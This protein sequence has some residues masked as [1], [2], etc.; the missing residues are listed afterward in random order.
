MTHSP[1]AVTNEDAHG[2]IKNLLPTLFTSLSTR[3]AAL[4]LNTLCDCRGQ[5]SGSLLSDRAVHNG[6]SFFRV[7]HI[8]ATSAC[9]GICADV[10]ASKL[11]PTTGGV[12]LQE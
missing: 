11:T 4:V 7:I 6:V 3:L 8:T 12:P 1:D 2:R 9:G 10:I 5:A